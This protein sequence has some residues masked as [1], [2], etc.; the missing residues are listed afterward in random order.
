M[1]TSDEIWAEV[2]DSLRGNA[3][4]SV[5]AAG[6]NT[7]RLVDYHD[8]QL[9]IGAPTQIQLKRVQDRDRPFITEQARSVLGENVRVSLT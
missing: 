7:L 2:R 1:S 3:S 4:A 5:W 8:D 6:L 9:V